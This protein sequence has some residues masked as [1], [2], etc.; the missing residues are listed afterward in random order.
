VA[1]RTDRLG[2]Q[3]I[4]EVVQRLREQ[5][6]DLVVAAAEQDTELLAWFATLSPA[7]RLDRAGRTAVALDRLRDARTSA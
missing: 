5:D 3:R 6:P 4:A 7:E 2:E 1:H